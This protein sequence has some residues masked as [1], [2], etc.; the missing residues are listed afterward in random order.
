MDV[1]RR[2]NINK[3]NFCTKAKHFGEFTVLQKS[4]VLP[5]TTN[6]GVVAIFLDLTAKVLKASVSH[7]LPESQEAGMGFR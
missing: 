5:Q 1:V 3:S 6:T 2:G 4:T 7:P